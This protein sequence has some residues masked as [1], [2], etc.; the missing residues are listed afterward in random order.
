MPL[1]RGLGV[2]DVA[3][4]EFPTGCAHSG[5]VP[6]GDGTAFPQP[7]LRK[8]F[9]HRGR[10][11]T[12]SI[13][14]TAEGLAC[15]LQASPSRSPRQISTAAQ[16]ESLQRAVGSSQAVGS[17]SGR[18]MSRGRHWLRGWTK[19]SH[20]GCA[21]GARGARRARHWKRRAP[22]A[23]GRR[24]AALPTG[25]LCGVR[26]SQVRAK[27]SAAR[28]LRFVSDIQGEAQCWTKVGSGRRGPCR[29]RRIWRRS[30]QARAVGSG[31][32]GGFGRPFRVA[33]RGGP[34]LADG[35]PPCAT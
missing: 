16:V 10:W 28:E 12:N 25:R 18:H 24:G 33:R 32:R 8:H 21:L 34:A 31:E 15:P 27:Q 26:A 1:Q 30:G 20:V 35:E 6:C 3:P 7:P 23:Q 19:A 22:S 17:T 13:A 4:S 11:Q 29:V 9:P 5:R 14:C 2:K